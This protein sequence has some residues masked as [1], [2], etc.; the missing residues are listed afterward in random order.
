[1]STVPGGR[2]V[3]ERGVLDSATVS[4]RRIRYSNDAR[5]SPRCIPR[6]GAR[7]SS[8]ADRGFWKP[9]RWSGR[10]FQLQARRGLP[11]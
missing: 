6:S 11:G 4:A 1:V 10:M 7:A 8:G 3:A 9:V 5:A 2:L